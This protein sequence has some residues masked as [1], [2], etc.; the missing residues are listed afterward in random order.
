MGRT[1][2]QANRQDDNRRVTKARLESAMMRSESGGGEGD[3]RPQELELELE[4]ELELACAVLVRVRV[5]C[6]AML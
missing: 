1:G 3:L 4:P 6:C 2:E 5:L